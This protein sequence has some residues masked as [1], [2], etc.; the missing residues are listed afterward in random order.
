[1]ARNLGDMKCENC[2]EPLEEDEVCSTCEAR[3]L[4]AM[5]EAREEWEHRRAI[6]K[7]KEYQDECPHD[8]HDHGICLDC[9]KDV[10]DD[11]VASAEFR[12]ECLRDE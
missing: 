1:M 11:V 8:E 7:Q 6:Q 10:W 4:E 9:G 5:L 3:M 12:A 2:G